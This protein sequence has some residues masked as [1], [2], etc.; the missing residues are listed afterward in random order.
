ML[1]PTD[2][3]PWLPTPA[4]HTQVNLLYVS[5]ARTVLVHADS[6]GQEYKVEAL[7]HTSKTQALV[8]RKTV[9]Y[10]ESGV[11]NG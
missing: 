1:E 8:V 4:V 6:D 11:K 3:S 7:L 9:Y 5:Y 2:Q 10:K